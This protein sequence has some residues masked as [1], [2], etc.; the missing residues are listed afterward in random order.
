MTRA[1][2]NIRTFDEFL[3]AC[4]YLKVKVWSSKVSVYD[5]EHFNSIITGI[6]PIT[7][8]VDDELLY[9]RTGT[10]KLENE[11]SIKELKIQE[12]LKWPK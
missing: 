1:V 12:L 3:V 6:K 2:T 10:S 11:I 5:E 7:I 4:K 9:E 8:I